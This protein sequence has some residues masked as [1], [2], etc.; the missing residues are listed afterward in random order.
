[1]LTGNVSV[2]IAGDNMPLFCP[3]AMVLGGWKPPRWGELGPVPKPPTLDS[4]V[5][6]GVGIDVL[7]NIAAKYF[8]VD[9]LIFANP[10][11][12]NGAPAI[13]HMFASTIMHYPATNAAK[14]T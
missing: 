5:L 6:T 4:I 7:R 2:Y 3:G 1:M 9:E 13:N 14:E 11:P 8:D 12:P 10:I